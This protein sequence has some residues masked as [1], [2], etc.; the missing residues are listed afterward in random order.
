MQ[1]SQEIIE[2]LDA[3]LCDG[4]NFVLQGQLDRKTYMAVNKILVAA[5]G[6]WNRSAKAHVFKCDAQDAIS[7]IVLTGKVV[8]AKREFDFFETPPDLVPYVMKYAEIR[9]NQSVLEPNAGGGSLAF[10][11]KLDGGNVTCVEIQDALIPSLE[12]GDYEA[13]VHGDFLEIDLGRVFDRIVMNPPF[14]KQADIKHVNRALDMLAP[15]GRLVAIMSAGVEFRQND[16]TA[17]FRERVTSMGGTIE[18]LPSASF[19]SS[20]TNVETALVVVEKGACHD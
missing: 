13:V 9:V 2:T 19:K 14:G 5:G 10:A 7:D 18:R 4:N 3:G 12:E 15:G 1:V 11:A 6:K 17:A 16:L 20:G 8:D